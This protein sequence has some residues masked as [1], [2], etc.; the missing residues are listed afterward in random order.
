M[1]WSPLSV[2]VVSPA[3]AS[4]LL[5][6][7]SV[8]SL[9]AQ[10]APPAAPSAAPTPAARQTIEARKAAFTLVGRNFRPI[11]EVLKGNVKY[12]DIDVTKHI[13]RI[14]F[15]SN[16]LQEEFPDSTNLG[17]PETKA[18]PDVWAN[19]ADF[20]KRL[21]DFQLHA[22]ALAEVNAR[23]KGLTDSVKT[24][25]TTLGQDCKGCHDTYKVK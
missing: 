13:A 6:A 7:S 2:R 18:K 22:V 10:T 1:S 9:S 15:L 23:D 5:A 8:I 16:L 17:E 20:D 24:A 21:H 3:V 25:V 19:R 11:G 14:A 4:M 12:E